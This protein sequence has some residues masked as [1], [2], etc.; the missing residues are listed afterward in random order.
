MKPADFSIAAIVRSCL[1]DTWSR[2]PSD[3]FRE[4]K[5]LVDRY[6]PC[7]RAHAAKIPWH[8]LSR[9]MTAA[10]VSGS[11]YLTGTESIGYLPALQP[12]SVVLRLGAQTLHAENNNLVLPTG[13]TGV[14]TQWLS[15]ENAP[16]TE[17]QP[18]IGQI[19]SSPKI[20][21]GLVEVSHQLLKQSNAEQVLRTE[22]SRAAG[23]AIDKAALAGSGA[24]GEPLGI[25]HTPGIGAFTGG[26]LNRSALTNAQLD[27]ADA[28]ATTSGQVGFVTTPTIA[29]TLANRADTIESTSP[30]WRGPLH[31]GLVI[32]TR[33]LSTRNCPAS[34]MIYGDWSNLSVVSWG[35]PEVAI[36]PF[37]KFN[38]GTVAIRLLLQVDIAVTRAAGFTVATSV[39]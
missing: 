18:T 12:A 14:T 27:V 34:T 2:I 36:D 39:S 3:E 6:G 15:D 38:Q 8:A 20:L 5:N 1:A 23:T 37:T 33:A 7:S 19:G 35:A 26:T 29:N 28:N 4:H 32:G 10:G 16:I 11:N 9:D 30:V 17:S 22:L 13:A 24:S 25:V 21:A 31:E